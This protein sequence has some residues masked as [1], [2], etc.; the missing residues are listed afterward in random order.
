MVDSRLEDWW[1][2]CLATE[3]NE[4][5]ILN[6]DAKCRNQQMSHQMRLTMT[7]ARREPS[8]W[9]LGTLLSKELGREPLCLGR[10][11]CLIAVR[12]KSFEASA[13]LEAGRGVQFQKMT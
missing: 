12:G 8:S 9:M 10:S 6:G 5:D 3:G 2:A 13:N 1:R 4:D 11:R 7:F